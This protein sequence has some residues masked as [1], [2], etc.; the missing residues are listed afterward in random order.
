MVFLIKKTYLITP[1]WTGL[2]TI[3]LRHTPV[4]PFGMK[5]IIPVLGEG[6]SVAGVEALGV[7]GNT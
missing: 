7:S 2:Q 4:Q 6:Y 3:K 5:V 1:G